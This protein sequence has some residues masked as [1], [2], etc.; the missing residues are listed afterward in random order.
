VK[1]FLIEKTSANALKLKVNQSPGTSGRFA[2]RIVII[3]IP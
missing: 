1:P 3:S 2:G